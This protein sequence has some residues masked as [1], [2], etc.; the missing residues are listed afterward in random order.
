MN[1]LTG[2]FMH[3]ATTP[4]RFTPAPSSVKAVHREGREQQ[5]TISYT[6][7]RADNLSAFIFW[8]SVILL[9]H[10]ISD[11]FS[12]KCPIFVVRIDPYF[13]L[14]QQNRIESARASTLCWH[15]ML[16]TFIVANHQLSTKSLRIQQKWPFLSIVC[17]H[18]FILPGTDW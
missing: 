7:V 17:L 12:R 10:R 3:S 13:E 18:T 2:S 9:F 5:L 16:L 15:P 11:V 6:D 4:P 8:G 14:E 1:P